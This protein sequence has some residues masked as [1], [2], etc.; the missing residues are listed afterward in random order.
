MG[1]EIQKCGWRQINNQVRLGWSFDRFQTKTYG[2]K[3]CSRC[4]NSNFL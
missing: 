4:C 3:C 2:K 1:W